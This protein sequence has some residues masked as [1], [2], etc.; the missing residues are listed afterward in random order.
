MLLFVSNPSAEGGPIELSLAYR[1]GVKDQ[2][3]LGHPAS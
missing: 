1:Q 3:G 2:G